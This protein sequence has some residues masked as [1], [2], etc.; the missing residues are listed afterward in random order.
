MITSHLR[1][2]LYRALFLAIAVLFG[3]SSSIAQTAAAPTPASESTPTQKANSAQATPE[4]P[5]AQAESSTNSS[6]P[7]NGDHIPFLKSDET[8]ADAPGA[9]GL[10][11]RTFGALL[12]IVGLIVGSAWGLKR[13]AGNRF[14]GKSDDGPSLAVLSTVSL[15]DRRSLSVVRF[16]D[17]TLLLGS[18]QQS[19]SLLCTEQPQSEAAAPSRSVAE[20]LNENSFDHQLDVAEQ[21]LSSANGS[22]AWR[23]EATEV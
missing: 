3:Q 21:F 15:G 5:A 18:T 2:H 17:K 11:L 19:I 22:G 9:G 1:N 13:F 8:A 14:A 10:L 7:S 6:N 16:G 12:L 20:L 4:S 23:D